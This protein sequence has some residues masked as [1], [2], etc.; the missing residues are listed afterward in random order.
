MNIINAVQQKSDEEGL[1][2]GEEQAAMGEWRNCKLH[3]MKG[4]RDLC[5]QCIV[6]CTKKEKKIL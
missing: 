1:S 2:E 6:K 4:T 3:R 5:M